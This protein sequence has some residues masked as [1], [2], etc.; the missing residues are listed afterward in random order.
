MESA[1]A[2]SRGALLY[3]LYVPMAMISEGAL[4]WAVSQRYLG[5]D[6]NFGA[7]MES[8]WK[9]FW[10]FVGTLL[11]SY[12]AI[13]GLVAVGIGGAVGVGALLFSISPVAGVLLG[14]LI[15]VPAL[16]AV[17]VVAVGLGFVP[18]VFIVEDARYWAAVRRSWAL[19]KPRFWFILE[20]DFLAGLIAGVIGMLGSVPGSLLQLAAA[21]FN[22]SLLAVL[23]MTM[24]G[25]VEGLANGITS[26][27]SLI[28]AVLLYFDCRVRSEGFD[29][30]LLAQEMGAPVPPPP[31][32][33]PISLG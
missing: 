30:A 8:V 4:I 12:L 21:S 25:V 7:A 17:F 28:P 16:L 32:V 9:R 19:V 10:P 26:P 33:E 11:S 14:L 6:V 1:A 5:G 3:I 24:K 20:V 13:I 31:P 23:A 18:C 29:I 27:L 22:Q 15:G 2:R